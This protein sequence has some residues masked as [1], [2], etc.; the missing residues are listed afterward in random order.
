MLKKKYII[1]LEGQMTFF[2]YLI[3]FYVAFRTYITNK[4]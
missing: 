2:I 4:E 3:M 1:L